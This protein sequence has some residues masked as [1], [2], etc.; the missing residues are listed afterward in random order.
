MKTLICGAAVS[1][2]ALGAVA[3]TALPRPALAAERTIDMT[4]P[5]VDEIGRPAKDVLAREP[6]DPTCAHCPVLTLG[7]AIAH[8]LFATLPG[9]KNESAEQKWARGVLA[10]RVRD[11]K[12]AALSAEELAL[13]K[14]DLAE[15]YG[16]LV[17][18]QTFPLLDPNAKPPTV[19]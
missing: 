7:H 13:I 1:L 4:V 2:A 6:D 11:N 5:L 16:S 12:A 8:A 9:D 17:I 18:M 15:A 19:K 14:R 3:A 10:D